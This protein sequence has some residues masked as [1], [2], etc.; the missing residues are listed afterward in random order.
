MLLYELCTGVDLFAKD[1]N[2][3]NIVVESDRQVA[4]MWL[5]RLRS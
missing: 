4:F 1:L 5:V 2:R 3:D